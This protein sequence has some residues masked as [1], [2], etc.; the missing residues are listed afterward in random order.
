MGG[1]NSSSFVGAIEGSPNSR[2]ERG[3][4]KCGSE[5]RFAKL[6]FLMSVDNLRLHSVEAAGWELT[7]MDIRWS[8][9]EFEFSVSSIGPG[10]WTVEGT[11]A[12]E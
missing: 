5:E 11:G 6:K 7:T 2:V 1:H 12:I 9:E 4:S 8:F 3:V 10:P